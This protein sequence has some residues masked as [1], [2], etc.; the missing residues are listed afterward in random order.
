[1]KPNSK[2]I[3]RV[4]RVLGNKFETKCHRSQIAVVED[5]EMGGRK[6]TSGHGV[7]RTDSTDN[8]ALHR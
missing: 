2:W 6:I 3:K 8:D 7:M 1:M 4:Q 5:E